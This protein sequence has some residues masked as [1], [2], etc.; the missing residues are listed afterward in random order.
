MQTPWRP[1][2]ELIQLFC[3]GWQADYTFGPERCPLR[4]ARDA[5]L[6]RRCEEYYTQHAA[7]AAELERKS[8][9]EARASRHH[10]AYSASSVP[11]G[12]PERRLLASGEEVSCVPTSFYKREPPL[13]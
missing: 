7:E 8:A 2:W 12:N 6:Q 11:A 13:W 9:E 5:A 4:V 1:P 10:D 3:P